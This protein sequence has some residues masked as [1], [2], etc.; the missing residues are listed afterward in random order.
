MIVMVVMVMVMLARWVT[1]AP[2]MA[3]VAAT[4]LM[5]V[6]VMA[7]VLNGGDTD[8]FFTAEHNFNARI[9][10]LSGCRGPT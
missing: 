8:A 10:L 4:L 7:L 3:M 5:M 9:A 2:I 6:G 1:V